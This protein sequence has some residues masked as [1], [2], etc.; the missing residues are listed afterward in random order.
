MTSKLK[1]LIPILFLSFSGA[2]IA[3]AS[4]TGPQREY[5]RIVSLVQKL[6]EEGAQCRNLFHNNSKYDR[7]KSKM[8]LSGSAT[9]PNSMQLSDME[10]PTDDDVFRILDLLRKL[11]LPGAM[12]A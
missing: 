9:S 11:A 7:I 4:E 12:P 2:L 10:P 8:P 5:K 3:C 1:P 6:Q